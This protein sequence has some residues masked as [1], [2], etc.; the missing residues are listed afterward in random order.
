MG[1]SRVTLR[2]DPTDPSRRPEGGG[3]G[4]AKGL[5][6]TKAAVF[7]GHFVG[8]RSPSLRSDVIKPPPLRSEQSNG[9]VGKACVYVI[10]SWRIPTL[11]SKDEGRSR[12]SLRPCN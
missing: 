7:G 4:K 2:I 12:I 11:V 3:R 9:G 8:L 1:R 5:E 6:R 10:L